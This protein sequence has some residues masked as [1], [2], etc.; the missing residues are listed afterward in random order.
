MPDLM[1]IY[2]CVSIFVFSIFVAVESVYFHV[3][4]FL[5]GAAMFCSGS[6]P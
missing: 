6:S 4:C 5:P 3:F 1:V 2:L